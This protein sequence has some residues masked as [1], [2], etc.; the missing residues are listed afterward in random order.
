MMGSLMN[1]VVIGAASGMGAAVAKRWSTTSG[2][3]DRLLLADRSEGAVS[4]LA[5]SLD[6]EFCVCDV[7]SSADV[8]DLCARIGAF[9]SAVITAGLS[10]TMGSGREI[11]EVNLAGTARVA[12][13]LLPQVRPDGA[14]VCF[15]STAGHMLDLSHLSSIFDEPLAD[16]LFDRLSQAGAGVDDPAMAY[17]T[18][19]YGVLRY[20]RRRAAAWGERGARIVSVSPGIIETP[21]G[22]QEFKAQPAM[23]DIVDQTP[24]RRVG[25]ADEVASMACFLA[26]TDASFVSG[27]DVLVDG[28]FMGAATK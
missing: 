21:M 13:A 25:R 7:T 1:R 8:A 3:E 24:I 23:R 27:C 22:A 18:S 15:A 14:V 19:K 28:G 5:S 20:V 4:A 10:P 9:D 26:S 2:P 12:E 16:E 11:I 17:M 6:T